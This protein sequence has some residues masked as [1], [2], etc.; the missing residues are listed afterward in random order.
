[1]VVNRR[2]VLLGA[3]SAALLAACEKAGNAPAAAPASSST[4]PVTSNPPRTTSSAP[5]VPTGPARFV[6]S[7]PDRKAVALT[8]HGSGDLALT[9]RLLDG[10]KQ[11]GAPITVFAV[12]Q[13]LDANPQMAA[14]IESA[15]NEL[16][17]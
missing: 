2:Q 10:A 17:N 6:Q 7:G 1:M 15:G 4:V 5:A 14:A 8:F 9:Q 3:L 13:W 12:G 16:A 11:A